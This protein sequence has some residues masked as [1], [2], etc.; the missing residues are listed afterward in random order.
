MRKWDDSA[1][2]ADEMASLDY[3]MDVP[4]ITTNGEVD[5]Q[6]LN[7]L[8]DGK[9]LGTLNKD[10]LYEIKDLDIRDAEDND[11]D[12]GTDDAIL[13]A[14]NRA[15]HGK[16]STGGS[17]QPSSSSFGNIGGLFARL[18]GSKVLSKEDLAPVLSTMKEHL[19][20][21]NVAKEIADKICEGVGEN[22]VGKKISG[23]NGLFQLN[24][25]SS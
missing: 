14:I 9:S 4:D 5:Q 12:D 24:F 19:M 15:S 13:E 6:Y 3:S 21:K 7:S 10:G 16:G 25:I 2:T 17:A 20:K 18:T 11:E 23:F 8:L 1:V 22:L